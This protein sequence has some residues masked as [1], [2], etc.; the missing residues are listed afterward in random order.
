MWAWDDN[1]NGTFGGLPTASADTRELAADMPE[2]A[3]D[4]PE[5][6]ADMH[7]PPADSAPR[8]WPAFTRLRAGTIAP[9][10]QRRT[11]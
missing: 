2:S 7:E 1:C 3:A 6:A 11:R 4:M 9:R 10:S 8:A 5:S